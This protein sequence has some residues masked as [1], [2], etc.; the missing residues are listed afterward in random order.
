MA[1]QERN[2]RGP[3][4]ATNAKGW[5]WS[6]GTLDL[7]RGCAP[8]LFTKRAR[9]SHPSGRYGGGEWQ[10]WGTTHEQDIKF[11]LVTFFV[12]FTGRQGALGSR[13]VS[14]SLASVRD[15]VGF[16]AH[17]LK[18]SRKALDLFVKASAFIS[19]VGTHLKFRHVERK[20]ATSIS[21]LFSLKV[22]A[23]LC[24]ESYKLLASVT[25]QTGN[26]DRL[27]CEAT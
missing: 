19:P 12:A 14:G 25:G 22:V 7:P 10:S 9:S 1:A 8:N 15:T 18:A 16:C 4:V 5:L 26:G 17:F 27:E 21:T 20:A 6:L 3:A 2:S 13:D 11:A 24:M 23:S